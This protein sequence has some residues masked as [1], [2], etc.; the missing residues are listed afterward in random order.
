MSRETAVGGRTV[1]T[2]SRLSTD[3]EDTRIRLVAGR[4]GCRDDRDPVDRGSYLFD[5]PVRTETETEKISKLNNRKSK[6]CI[7]KTE[8]P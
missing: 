7:W 8:N 1:D 4:L 6:R 2:S 5:V 3:E